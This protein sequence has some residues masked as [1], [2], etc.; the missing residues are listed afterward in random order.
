MRLTTSARTG[1]PAST[2]L[3]AKYE[4]S[5][6]VSRR[7]DATRTKA[8]RSARRRASTSDARSLNPCS[9]PSKAWKKAMASSMTSAPTTLAMERTK[10][11]AAMFTAFSTP[12]LDMVSTL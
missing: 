8:V 6:I 12:R 10:D 9:M 7:G 4:A 11:C 1:I 3:S 2:S 5:A